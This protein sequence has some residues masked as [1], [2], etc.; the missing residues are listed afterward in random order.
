M[1]AVVLYFSSQGIA[2][3]Q[4][5]NR[6]QLNSEINVETNDSDNNCIVLQRR[7]NASCIIFKLRIR[8]IRVC[9]QSIAQA[10]KIYQMRMAKI[11]KVYRYLTVHTH[12]QE[13]KTTNKV[14]KLTLNKK[15][16]THR[17]RVQG[18]FQ[19]SYIQHL[20]EKALILP[21]ALAQD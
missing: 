14:S 5:K 11:T 12:K 17:L 15:L 19:F 4:V 8:V 21:S 3:L 13:T 1:A 20:V 10:C 7:F 2:W 9:K 18:W 16:R 6:R